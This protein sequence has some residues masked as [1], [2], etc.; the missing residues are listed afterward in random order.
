MS[1]RD[2]LR[3]RSHDDHSGVS[4]ANAPESAVDMGTGEIL[5][6]PQTTTKIPRPGNSDRG[7]SMPEAIAGE[8]TIPSVNRERSVQS[9]VGNALAVGTI[10][11]F[12]G[13]F[14]A[15]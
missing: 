4:A 13:G 6:A 7:L 14:L 5:D 10:V 11:L 3:G 2:W 9:R 8:R 15:W 1:I 12:G